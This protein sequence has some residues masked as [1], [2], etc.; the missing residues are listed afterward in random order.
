V[1]HAGLLT[2]V[3]VYD[4]A[5]KRGQYPR[6]GRRVRADAPLTVPVTLRLAEDEAAMVR[7]AAALAGIPVAQFLRGTAVSASASMLPGYSGG[8]AIIK[9]STVEAAALQ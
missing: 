1:F 2:A 4:G 7:E 6:P 3:T 5:M 8:E 9:D